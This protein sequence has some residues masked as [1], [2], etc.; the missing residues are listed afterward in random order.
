MIHYPLIFFIPGTYLNLNFLI[1][2]NICDVSD[3]CVNENKI[4]FII[5]AVINLLVILIIKLIH[6][7]FARC[8]NIKNDNIIFKLN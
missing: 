5:I 1:D 2:S 8:D 6:L 4:I 7:Y 3:F